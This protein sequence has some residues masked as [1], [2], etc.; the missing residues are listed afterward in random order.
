MSQRQPRRSSRGIGVAAVVGSNGI[1]GKDVRVFYPLVVFRFVAFL[2]HCVPEATV[3]D[4][5]LEDVLNFPLRVAVCRMGGGLL[6]R[7]CR[8]EWPRC[9][10][11]PHERLGDLPRGSKN[12][13]I[14]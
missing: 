4:L 12:F 7:C 10:N 3:A 1:F 6:F 5:R 13:N 8:V 11:H 14:L 2:P 9:R